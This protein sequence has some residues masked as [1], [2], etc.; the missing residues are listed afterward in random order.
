MKFRFLK[1]VK[2]FVDKFSHAMLGRICFILDMNFSGDIN[3]VNI[4]AYSLGC[5]C[6]FR[7]RGVNTDV[8]QL[9]FPLWF[10]ENSHE[11]V[12]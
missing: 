3:M 11:L 2:E 10:A 4:S 9:I 5:H 8:I 7:G 6:V 12:A 1:S